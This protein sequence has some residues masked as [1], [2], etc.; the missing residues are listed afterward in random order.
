MQK[1]ILR[2]TRENTELKESIELLKK[3]NQ[4]LRETDAKTNNS[5]NAQKKLTNIK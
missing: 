4:R 5:G 3:E 1:D 2:L